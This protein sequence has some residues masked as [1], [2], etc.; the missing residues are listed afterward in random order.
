R[1]EAPWFARPSEDNDIRAV[2]ADLAEATDG[3]AMRVVADIAGPLAQFVEDAAGRIA[4][5]GGVR[6]LEPNTYEAND[7][8][9]FEGARPMTAPRVLSDGLD[10]HVGEGVNSDQHP[11]RGGGELPLGFTAGSLGV[12]FVHARRGA[13]QLAL[14]DIGS[15]KGESL[16]DPAQEVIAGSISADGRRAALTL[17]SLDT[18]GDLCVYDLEQRALTR[19]WDP[20]DELLAAAQLGQ[21]E[22]LEYASFDGERIQG[23]LVKPADFDPK[24]KYPLVLEIHGGPHTAYGVGFFHEFH[25]LAEAGYLVL[26]TKPRG[27]TSY[28]QRFADSIQYRFPGDDVRDLMAG[29][30]HVIALGCVDEARLGVTGGSGG[31]LLTN[32]IVC[33]SDRF[34]AAITQR[35]V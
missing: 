10:L 8:L 35:C 14:C 26:Y 9:L 31:G 18:P 32:W 17:G 6:P 7:L 22:E 24:R 19:L 2:A 30:D 13:A 25:V 5:V 4:A 3:D 12:V 21:V 23:W 34:A 16:T 11:P 20:N 27:S 1:R 33:H 15:G 28:G 29:V